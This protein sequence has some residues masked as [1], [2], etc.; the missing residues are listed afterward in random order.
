MIRE[1]GYLDRRA[2]VEWFPW[3]LDAIRLLNRAGYLV[4]VVSNQG[5]IGLG[6]FDDAFV[7][8][9]H[10]ALD[11]EVRASG[12]T[13]DG[14][15]HCPHHPRAVV[16]DLQGPCDCRKPGRGMI[17]QACARW[18]IDLSRSWVVGDRDV[19]VQMA[20]AVGARGVLVKTGHGERDARL[21]AASFPAGTLVTAHLMEAVAQIL[22]ADRAHS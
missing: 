13:I 22:V 18:E 4:C 21:R 15:F 6:L 10:A 12:G 17:D 8:D 2:D 1:V 9:L 20:Q 7:R 3:T 11:E 5:G 14:W 16:L 19:D